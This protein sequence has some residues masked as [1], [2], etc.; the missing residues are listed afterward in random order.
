MD[1][2]H[3]TVA[4][5]VAVRLAGEIGAQV[6]PAGIVSVRPTVLVKP[7]R[8]VTVIV[9]VVVALTIAAAGVDAVIE[10]S[11]IWKVAVAE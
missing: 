1:A 8:N 6:S 3:E 4:D 5:P 9:E 11:V 10:K 2:L 7:L